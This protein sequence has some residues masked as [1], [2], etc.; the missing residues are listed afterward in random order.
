M[1]VEWGSVAEWATAGVTAFAALVT[2]LAAVAAGIAVY[3]AKRA[4]DF[5]EQTAR[6]AA[7]SN[8]LTAQA[9]REDA[10]VRE[11][12][13][14]R[15]IYSITESVYVTFPGHVVHQ[16][17]ADFQMG[18]GDIFEYGDGSDPSSPVAKV[19]VNTI[20]VA[21]YNTSNE[22]VGPVHFTVYNRS[23]G[24]VLGAG[25]SDDKPLLPNGV[26]RATI[27][28]PEK[29]GDSWHYGGLITFRDSA[30]IWW[31][32]RD[33]DPIERLPNDQIWLYDRR[34]L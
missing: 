34:H 29:S 11:S 16:P 10:R 7:R 24:E 15:F 25:G 5:S 6:E 27:S 14:A 19:A 23:T 17:E 26:K 28:L 33:Y 31:T 20:T 4:N 9:F 21:A 2:L 32:R 1:R 13:Q 8:E 3:F 22:I 30:G 18:A 12:E